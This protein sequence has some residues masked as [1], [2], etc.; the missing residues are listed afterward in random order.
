MCATAKYNPD[1]SYYWPNHSRGISTHMPL[2]VQA[3]CTLWK[4][5]LSHC[6]RL[7]LRLCNIDRNFKLNVAKS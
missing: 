6:D 4:L 2:T 7:L 3:Q 1:I 5:P